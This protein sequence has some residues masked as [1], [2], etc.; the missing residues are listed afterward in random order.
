VLD[1]QLVSPERILFTG[2]AIGVV[3]RTVGGGDI[4]FLTGH[5][6]FIGALEIHP[7]RVIQGANDE[8][9]VAV[10]GGFVEVS[11]DKVTLL[12][13]VAELPDQIDRSRAEQSLAAANEALRTNP[14]DE[15]ARAA[16]RRAEVRLEVA[17]V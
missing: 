4:Q 3:C 17:A 5:T 11:D 7:V 14:D 1:V 8:V 12:S 2:E 9:V 10:H 16:L 15:E 6:S 13:D